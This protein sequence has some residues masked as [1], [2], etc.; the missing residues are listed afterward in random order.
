MTKSDLPHSPPWVLS[1]IPEEF[2]MVQAAGD[3]PWNTCGFFFFSII[4]KKR[5]NMYQL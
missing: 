3:L 4:K 2:S 1:V 5:N